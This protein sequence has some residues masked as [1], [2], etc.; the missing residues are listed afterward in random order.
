MEPEKPAEYPEFVIFPLV[1]P[2]PDSYDVDLIKHHAR[3]GLKN[4]PPEDRAIAWLVFLEVYP[5]NPNLW[6][7]ERKK[8]ENVYNMY[9]EMCGLID[10]HK[11]SFPQ[12]IKKDVFELKN[13]DLMMI[14]HGDIVRTGR[15]IFKLPE[16]KFEGVEYEDE[17]ANNPNILR[18]E[19]HMRRLE[20]ILYILGS[21][22]PAHSYMQGFNELLVPIYYTLFQAKA[23]FNN[24]IDEV[25]YL[26]FFCIHKLI[27]LTEITDLFTTQDKSSILIHRLNGFNTVL[28]KRVPLCYD[29]IQTHKIH[30][31]CYCFRWF[32]LLFSQD[33]EIPDLLYIWDALLTHFDDLVNYAFYIGAAQVK[34]VEKDI[35][36]KNYAKTI[37]TLQNLPPI[38][39]QELLEIADN[40]WNIDHDSTAVGAIQ[41]TIEQ[42]KNLFSYAG[43]FITDLFDENE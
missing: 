22:N 27:T 15:H 6:A 31:V 11:R 14:I 1:Q 35:S 33:Y 39:I 17:I 23:L 21:I 16:W 40:W 24:S 30:P 10:F 2:G 4:S 18:W 36:D 3:Y 19:G 38:D 42:T 28:K 9:K 20:R 29:A 25:E 12:Y 7:E 43:K 41:Q 32:S 37:D 5:R 26:S 13:N 34:L 8:N